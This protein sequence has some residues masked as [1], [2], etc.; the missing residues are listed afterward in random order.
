MCSPSRCRSCRRALRGLPN[1]RKGQPM[2]KES[3]RRIPLA[4]S[5]PRLG[6]E[7]AV[8]STL[9]DSRV[10]WHA[11][12]V[13]SII[14]GMVIAISACATSAPAN[15]DQ[16]TTDTQIPVPRL[17]KTIELS[18]YGP[19]TSLFRRMT[20]SPDGRFLAIVYNST[21]GKTDILVWDI[22]NSRKQTIIHPPFDYGEFSTEDIL[23]LPKVN[24]I[25]FGANRNNAPPGAFFRVY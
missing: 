22:Q 2:R 7:A 10:K 1:P 13:R 8:A 18:D 12:A 14:A 21:R 25:C 4:E 11:T 15:S 24:V 19:A 9:R 23:W 16:S 17:Q 3:L 20:F 6:C 5:T